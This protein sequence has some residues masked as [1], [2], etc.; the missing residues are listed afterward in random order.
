MTH[1]NVSTDNVEQ[2]GLWRD[3]HCGPDSSVQIGIRV[4]LSRILL[5]ACACEVT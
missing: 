5:M 2:R 4:P 1:L 3:L